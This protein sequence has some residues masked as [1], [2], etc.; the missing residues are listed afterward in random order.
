MSVPSELEQFRNIVITKAR[1]ILKLPA[2][3]QGSRR[4]LN[5]TITTATLTP[6]DHGTR[7]RSHSTP[8]RKSWI[9]RRQG[10]AHSERKPFP[11]ATRPVLPPS[12]RPISFPEGKGFCLYT[13]PPLV[14]VRGRP[15]QSQHQSSTKQPIACLPGFEALDKNELAERDFAP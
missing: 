3:Q 2:L 9:P 12:L 7:C 10:S 13:S 8:Y 4:W 15:Q 11:G 6:D 1:K 5:T 14:L